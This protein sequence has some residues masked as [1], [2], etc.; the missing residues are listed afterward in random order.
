[1]SS[2]LLMLS[3]LPHALRAWRPSCRN[4][5]TRGTVPWTCSGRD[6]T[7]AH[8]SIRVGSLRRARG[9]IC[10]G[11]VPAAIHHR[12]LLDPRHHGTQLGPDLL[13]RMCGHLG[14]HRLER[15]LV[16]AVLQHPVAGEGAGLDV[17]ED[18][19]HLRARLIGDH[20][21]AG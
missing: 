3:S 8:A 10:P 4:E 7:N 1:M 6:P 21:R 15:G 5:T 9:W 14:A 19:L 11:S 18:A 16:D 12:T 20:P 13:D 17:G 2:R